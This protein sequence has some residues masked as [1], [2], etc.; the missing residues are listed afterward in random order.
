MTRTPL[1]QRK[2]QTKRDAMIATLGAANAIF[3][4]ARWFLMCGSAMNYFIE[5]KTLR[6][7]YLVSYYNS[8]QNMRRMVYESDTTSVVNIRM[9]ICAFKTLC[10]I[11]ETR[12]G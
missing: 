11:I 9:T 5:S 3:I 8:L 1:L 12:G 6:K 10:E 2:I 7:R 4:V